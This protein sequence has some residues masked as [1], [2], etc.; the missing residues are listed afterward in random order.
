MAAAVLPV[1]VWQFRQ[2]TLTARGGIDNAHVQPRFEEYYLKTKS[3]T[4]VEKKR[5]S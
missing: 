1:V 2:L 5:H 3:G 4:E